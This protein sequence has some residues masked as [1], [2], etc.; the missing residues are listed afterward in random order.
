M[1]L[2]TLVRSSRV[3]LLLAVAFAGITSLH[4]QAQFAGTYFGTINTKVSAG[5]F[6]VESSL[7]GYITS[8]TVA[9]AIDV[10]SGAITGTVNASGAVTFTGGTAFA[11]FGLHSA[12]IANN[13]LSSAYG[14][15][16]A[17]GTS[18]YKLNASTSFQAASGGSTGG[19]STGGGATAG[20]SFQNGSFETGP[21][22]G[23]SWVTLGSG[24]TSIPGWR[25]TQGDIDYIG[26]AWSNSD[27]AR[28]IDL[29]G[30]SAGGLA[31]TFSTTS[32]HTYT[33]TFD[34]AG[35]PGFGTGTGVKSITASVTGANGTTSLASNNY[36]FDTTG[37]TLA[38][39]GWVNKSFTFTADGATATLTFRSTNDSAYGPALDNVRLDG[40]LGASSGGATTGGL[41]AQF[42]LDGSAAE[43]NNANNGAASN[44]TYG[45]G[46]LGQAAQFNGSNSFISFG[47]TNLVSDSGP[48]TVSFWF[49]PTASQ[50]MV[51]LRLKTASTEFATR[52]GLD[53]SD[54][55]SLGASIYFGFR[56]AAGIISR[57]PRYYIANTLNQWTQI[58]IVYK[59]GSKTSAD[60][61]DLLVNGER[62]AL[63]TSGT[64]GGNA[65][66]NEIGR[67][68]GGGS[69]VAGLIDDVR[70]YTS[71]LS[72]NDATVL[73][74]AAPAVAT[75]VDV[76]PTNLTGYRNKVGQT[77]QFAV[78]GSTSGGVWG[79]DIYTDDSSIGRA[80]VHAG[81]VSVGETKTV[82]ITILPGQSS[83]TASNRNGIASSSWG[84]WTGSY[85]FAGSG[86][87]IGI[88][89]TAPAVVYAPPAA[90]TVSVGG[91]L[92]LSVTIGGVGPFT[93]QWFLNGTAITGATSATYNLA[94]AS[95][96]NAG[97]Y[98][99]RTT[100]AAGSTTIN[101]GLVTVA[102]AGA[103]SITLQ[104]LS[105]TVAPGARFTLI[106]S[107]TGT[108]NL[109]YQWRKDG[110]AIPG[111]TDF[112]IDS[113]AT[114]ASAG[115]YT[116]TI[117]NSAG[118]ITTAAAVV[119][120]AAGASRPANISC[121][122]SIAAGDSVTPGF[123][124]QGTASKRVLIRAVGPGLAA[125]GIG[126]LMADPQFK[127]FDAASKQIAANDNWDS[128]SV[129]ADAAAVGAFGITAGSKDAALIT[130]LASNTSYTVQVSGAGT[131]SGLVIIEVYD[132]D[133][134][135][136]ATSR[137]T[138]VSVLGQA[139]LHADV[140]TLGLSVQGS[141]KRTLLVRGIGPKLA[142]AF[143]V[144][145]T[146]SDPRLEI[147]DSNNRSVL[148]NDNWG[149]AAFVTEQVLAANAVGAFAL[150]T[151]SRDAA[152]LCL[153]DPGNYTIQVKGADGGTGKA[154]VEVYDIP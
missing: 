142:S 29:N 84:A 120:I 94:S 112:G 111:A 91:R 151:G 62:L 95:S 79:T 114:A 126:G 85:S 152:T 107:A 26:T 149:A 77:F 101:A 59:G 138:N 36:T 148:D 18:Q 90:Q 123:F 68:G 63:T 43:A 58:T 71:A 76:A 35:N 97:T 34:L 74:A 41:V 7:A 37:K 33:V 118:S 153:L 115:S 81:V 56:G 55:S 99:V 53:A 139:G 8:V 12:I 102:N 44:I 49:K 57:D 130:T 135:A 67:D 78:T 14:D 131:S 13:Q 52:I 82:A 27:G 143:G 16:V 119:S 19:G 93:Y 108:G 20:S 15:V 30:V 48:F 141:G 89:T 32:G 50:I 116:C 61:F 80:A 110:F 88:A 92:T 1:H 42:K 66:A 106:V 5:G 21:N 64:V 86:G 134:P 2:T 28:G 104:P 128:A 87:T 145:G 132:L 38:T 105:K 17:N 100:N 65:N 72:L 25:V 117:T 45:T 124:V 4:A 122:T 150:D 54:S 9:G 96:A 10:N 146:L 129:A 70:I 46:V 60:S 69:T 140:L 121:R 136:T 47:S 98:T 133:N 103:P 109:G 6:N 125:F 23:A 51:P 127:V 11:T 39:M 154:L 24:A 75:G 22:P 113:T 144:P 3:G 83:Y 147:F 31:Q 73:Y 137:L 40:S